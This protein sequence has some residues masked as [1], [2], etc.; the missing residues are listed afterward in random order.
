MLF[1]SVYIKIIHLI[2]KAFPK[3]APSKKIRNFHD[4][5]CT[6]DLVGRGRVRLPKASPTESFVH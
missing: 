2:K 4:I 6:A 3:I 1:F 5:I